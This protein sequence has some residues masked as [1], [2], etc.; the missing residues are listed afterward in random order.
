MVRIAD[1]AEDSLA[2]I[3]A[4]SRFGIAIAAMIRIAGIAATPTYPRTS[5]AIANPS[6][7]RRPALLRICDRERCPRTMA[8]IDIGKK[9]RKSPLTRLA[10]AIP[11]VSGGCAGAA[12]ADAAGAVT[13][14]ADVTCAPQTRQK[15]SA[16]FMA[17]PQAAQR[18]STNPPGAA[19]S[20]T[21]I[22][23]KH[24]L[25]IPLRQ[26]VSL[27]HPICR[28]GIASDMFGPR[29]TILEWT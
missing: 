16:V 4:R 19:V 15:R 14:G 29:W 27:V 10:T 25:R 11:L 18:M 24:T 8:T 6:P 22:F 5:P 17:F 13:A 20:G 9:N 1:T 2:A 3:R 7:F 21:E 26:C 23:T 12:G 28:S